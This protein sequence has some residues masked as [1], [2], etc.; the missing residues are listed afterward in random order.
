M[1]KRESLESLV[2]LLRQ[3]AQAEAMATERNLAGTGVSVPMRNLL[4]ELL[5]C[6]PMTVPAL[7]RSLLVTRQFALILADDLAA[8]G[9]VSRMPNPA[10]RRS[11]LVALTPE[12]RLFIRDVVAM[13]RRTLAPVAQ[14]MSVDELAL[15]LAALQSVATCF[16]T[17]VEA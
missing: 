5:V 12:G 9:L 2:R 17:D 6:G 15:V 13:G 4:S 3:A 14:T 7:A 1:E 8:Q 10:H 11:P 16:S